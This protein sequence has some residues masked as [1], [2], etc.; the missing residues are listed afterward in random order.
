MA[1]ADDISLSKEQRAFVQEL[2]DSGEYRSS[3]EAVGEALRLLRRRRYAPLIRRW[4]LEGPSEE[5]E[6]ELPADIREEIADRISRMCDEAIA[7]VRAG[8]FV[9]GDEAMAKARA[10]IERMKQAEGQ[11]RRSA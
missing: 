4:M 6:R 1:D 3:G 5:L 10:Y 11:E 7:D 2:I 8:N 9:D